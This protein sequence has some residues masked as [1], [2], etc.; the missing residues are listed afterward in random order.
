MT[1]LNKSA[2]RHVRAAVLSA[3]GLVGTV[4]WQKKDLLKA[5]VQLKRNPDGW[6]QVQESPEIFLTDSK[7]TS[8]EN[9]F[10][11]LSNSPWRLVDQVAD[12]YFWINRKE[13][14]LLLSQ[15][16]VMGQYW[17]WS[18]SRPFFSEGGTERQSQP[19]AEK[20]EPLDLEIAEQKN[21]EQSSEE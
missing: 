12:G 5:A 15:K 7:E 1:V 16:K 19:D 21:R 4:L 10:C 11:Y 9:L 13:E 6:Q 14:I 2:R 8:K 18:A 20:M 17:L 3:T